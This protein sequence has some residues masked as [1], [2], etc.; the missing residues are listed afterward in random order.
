MNIGIDGH[1]IGHRFGGNESYFQNIITSLSCI[2][3]EKDRLFVF[4]YLNNKFLE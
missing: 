2:K 4:T 3:R 1:F